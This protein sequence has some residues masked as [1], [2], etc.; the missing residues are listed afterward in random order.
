[1]KKK[2]EEKIRGENDIKTNTQESKNVQD[3]IFKS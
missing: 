1:M 2:E 3:L